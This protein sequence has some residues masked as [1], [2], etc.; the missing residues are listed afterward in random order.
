MQFMVTSAWGIIPADINELSPP[1]LRGF[2]PGIVY[3]MGVLG[4]SSISYIEARLGEHL[5]YSRAMS[6]SMVVVLMC[7]WLILKF[8]P[9]AKGVAFVKGKEP[10]SGEKQLTPEAKA[11]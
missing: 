5:T 8:G 7:L 6:M 9:E 3:Q 11:D 4:A 10:V 1:Q 2:F